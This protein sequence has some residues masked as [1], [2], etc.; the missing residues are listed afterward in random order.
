MF[1]F[2]VGLFIVLVVVDFNFDGIF[3]VVVVMSE[4]NVYVLVGNGF[5]NF[6]EEVVILVGVGF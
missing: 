4:N 3:D 6:I 2:I 5:G 1:F